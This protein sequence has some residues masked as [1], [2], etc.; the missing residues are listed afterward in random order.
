[1]PIS[2]P[3]PFTANG[4]TDP[5]VSKANDESSLQ[6]HRDRVVRPENF[7]EALAP[8]AAL[9]L[10]TFQ[11]KRDVAEAVLAGEIPGASDL[12]V[13][14]VV[15]NLVHVEL[16]GYGTDSKNRLRDDRD[17]ELLIRA[18][19]M[20]CKR[21]AVDFPKLP[22]RNFA[23]FYS[24]W[25]KEGMSGSWAARREYLQDLFDPIEEAI[26]TLQM[27]V[28]EDALL[29]PVSPL[30][31]TGWSTVD[32][33]IQDLRR[34]FEAARSPQDY[35]SVGTACI[36]VLE[37]VGDAGFDPA[38][39]LSPGETAAPPRDRTKDRLGRIVQVELAG[40]DAVEIRGLVNA[41]IVVAHHVKHRATPNRREAGMA[42][43][44]A[45][46]VANLLR[47]AL[48]S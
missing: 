24:Y 14:D 33:E 7:F 31:R 32:R 11:F 41:S 16:E 3:R 45:I 34:R 28:F 20:A 9:D 1:M 2:L 25:K 5:L 13:A 43:D 6:G 30:R 26:T 10:E 12:E 40:I 22:F 48:K 19:R 15:V 8:V 46:L 42:A 35:A 23:T 17:V 4:S 38:K 37:A 39:H 21:I 36:R 27:R 29:D 47:R 18:A 44:A